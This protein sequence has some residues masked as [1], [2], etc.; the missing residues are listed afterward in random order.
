M[1]DAA[2]DL[3]DIKVST[4]DS[5]DCVKLQALMRNSSYSLHLSE[6]VAYDDKVISYREVVCQSLK[7]VNLGGDYVNFSSNPAEHNM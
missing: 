6:S 5:S 4:I 1:Q 2:V 3:L 7:L